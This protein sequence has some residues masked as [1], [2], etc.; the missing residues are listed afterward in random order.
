MKCPLEIGDHAELLAYTSQKLEGSSAAALERHMLSCSACRDF[1][2]AQRAVWQ[3]LD[4]WDAP[5][6]SSG[7][8]RDLYRA[9]EQEQAR[10]GGG[11]W[12]RWL[13][14][15]PLL[16]RR[17]IPIAAAACLLVAAGLMLENPPGAPKPQPENIQVETLQPDQVQ[18]ALDDMEMLSNFSRAARTDGGEL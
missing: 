4:A 7:F 15:Q 17:G 2:T 12:S 9:I 13:A 6:V 3:A 18:H 8:D 16:V 10:P 1:A 5:K 11:W 14:P